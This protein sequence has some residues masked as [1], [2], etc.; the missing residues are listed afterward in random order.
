MLVVREQEKERDKTHSSTSHHRFPNFPFRLTLLSQLWPNR[1]MIPTD[2]T[3]IPKHLLVQKRKRNRSG[4][5]RLERSK[6]EEDVRESIV[7][8]DGRS[9]LFETLDKDFEVGSG[10]DDLFDE[11]LEGRGREVEEPGSFGMRREGRRELEKEF[12]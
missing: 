3:P 8:F 10:D 7:C 12:G 5:Q 11:G 4:R 2:D 6:T 9:D 1:T